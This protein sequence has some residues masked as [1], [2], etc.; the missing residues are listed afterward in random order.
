[1][2]YAHTRRPSLGLVLVLVL[3]LVLL[4]A[5]LQLSMCPTSAHSLYLSVG[6]CLPLS[7]CVLPYILQSI[8]LT[9]PSC[10]NLLA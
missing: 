8:K 10:L 4:L 5:L 7:L 3:V 9:C 1:M 2:K 6:R